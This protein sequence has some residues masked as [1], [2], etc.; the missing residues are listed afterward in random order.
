[1]NNKNKHLAISILWAALILA[2]S[3]L[4]DSGEHYAETVAL[5]CGCYA[6]TL[7]VLGAPACRRKSGS[8]SSAL[9]ADATDT[10]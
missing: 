9:A 10:G 4:F 8:E 3:I 2:V 1:M 5:L 7:A 6:A